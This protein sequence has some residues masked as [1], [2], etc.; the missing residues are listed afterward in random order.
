MNLNFKIEKVP[1]GYAGIYQVDFEDKNVDKTIIHSFLEDMDDSRLEKELFYDLD[2]WGDK[3]LNGWN[4]DIWYLEMN[5]DNTVTIA[6]M[7]LDEE[8]EEDFEPSEVT[9]SI[10]LTI[11]ELKDLLLEYR[12]KVRAF[13]KE[14]V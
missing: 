13:K 11:S 1:E 9:P 2:H 4:S 8:E 3:P 14:N 7:Y 6:D 10:T 12:K 5:K